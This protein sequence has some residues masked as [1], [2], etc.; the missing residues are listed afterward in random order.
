MNADAESIMA[1]LKVLGFSLCEHATAESWHAVAVRD[2]ITELATG[3]SSTET[4]WVLW[5]RLD[6]LAEEVTEP[7][8]VIGYGFPPPA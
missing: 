7:D 8:F 2:G 5:G 6:S 4:W 1:A 3:A